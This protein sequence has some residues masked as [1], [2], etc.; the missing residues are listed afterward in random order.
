MKIK[1]LMD[2][3]KVKVKKAF[4]YDF[5]G[6]DNLLFNCIHYS[7]SENCF[8]KM[9]DIDIHPLV[10]DFKSS[11]GWLVCNYGIGDTRIILDMLTGSTWPLW[12]IYFTYV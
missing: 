11:I 3:V 7:M 8:Y 4:C 2:D 5:T 12:G 1:K 6:D 9:E 10:Q